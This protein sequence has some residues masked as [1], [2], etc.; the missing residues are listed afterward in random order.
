MQNYYIYASKLIT[1]KAIQLLFLILAPIYATG[2]F[3]DNFSDGNFTQNPAWVGD[4][5]KFV[6]ENQVLRLND[7]VAGQSYLTTQSSITLETQWDFWVRIAF[8][9]SNN[10]HPR[11][12]LVSNQQN[13]RGSLNGYYLQ[14]GRDGTDNKR[15]YLVRQDG[16][17]HVELLRGSQNLATASNNLIRIRVTRTQDG[18]WNVLADGTGGVFFAPQG[19]VTDLTHTTTSWFGVV[20]TYTVSNANRF[21]FDDFVVG[22]II[23]DNTAPTVSA[24]ELTSPTSVNVVFSEPVYT[25][26]AQ[27]TS[28][29]TVNRG[30]GNPSSATQ[31]PATPH[32]VTLIFGQSFAENVIYEIDIDNIQDL[33]GNTMVNFKGTFANFVVQMHGVVFNELMVRPS[34]VVGLPAHEYIELYNTTE[35][36]V[37]LAGWTLQHGTTRRTIPV[38]IIEP[39]G[40]FL[41]STVGAAPALQQ[42]GNGMGVTGLSATALTDG[43]TSLL[44]F[45]QAERLISFVNYTDQW[46]RN[47]AKSTGGWSLE[48]IDPLNFCEGAGNWAAS[49]DPRGGT[50]GLQNSIRANNLDRTAPELARIGFENNVTIL[51]HFSESMDP[52]ILN[53]LAGQNLGAGVVTAV[54]PMLPDFR[55]VL[56]IIATPLVANQIY[57]ITLPPTLTDCA[58]NIISRRTARVAIPQPAEPFDMV[59][60]E[61][62]FNPPDSGSRYVEI[63]N[64]SNKVIELRDHTISSKDTISGFLTTIREIT[65]ESFLFFPGDYVVLTANPDAVQRTFLTN[66]PYGFIQLP[67]APS[68]TNTSGILVLA[69]KS[70]LEIDMFAY[71]EKM[72]FALLTS[73]KG[74]ALE[75]INYHRPTQDRSNWHSAAQGSGFGTPGFK[76]SQFSSLSIPTVGE[77]EVYPEVFSPDGDGVDDFLTISYKLDNP[78][79]VATVRVFDSRGRLVKNLVRADLLGIEG[80]FTWDGTTDNNLKAAIGIYLVLV[81]ITGIDGTVNRHRRTTVLAGRF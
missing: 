56:L 10:N 52:A 30:V 31:L 22:P 25:H 74:V 28:N 11:I 80:A 16:A 59:L 21:Y 2:Q 7:N 20:C 41:L 63:Y 70:L 40:Y 72:H 27:N 29:Y 77:I 54:V 46:Y 36:P 39:F 34:P 48:K 6:I 69:N 43:G 12:Y 44:L 23:V 81:E 66:N 4:I 8:S 50:P 76:N 53:D 38:G 51:L 62:L 37:N 35:F 67:T 33:S 55:R 49:N 26:S 65:V 61:V 71:H 79:Y 47:P 68:M 24:V 14:I 18:V 73:R 42:F 15:I 13:L 45:S 19:T 9:P 75:R 1:M 3:S 57:E 64:R 78:G 60:N 17:T 5:D 32:I 58:G